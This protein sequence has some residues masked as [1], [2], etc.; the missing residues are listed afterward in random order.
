MALTAQQMSDTRRYLGYALVGTTMQIDDN[1]DVVYMTFGLVYMSLYTRLTTL[2]P[3]EETTLT[4]VYLPNLATLET[5]IVGAGA[6]L[7]TDQASVWKHNK[8]EVSDRI[9]LYNK[10]RREMCAFIGLPPGPGL[11]DG[12]M[13]IARG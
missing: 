5:A 6:N 3:E 1:E 7:D 12:G 4:T 9:G 13:A 11:G 8:D 10:W 2:L